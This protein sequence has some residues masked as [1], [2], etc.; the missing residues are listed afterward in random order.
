MLQYC[1]PFAA[2]LRIIWML[3]LLFI[4]LRLLWVSQF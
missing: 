4:L 1:F 3:L 2:T